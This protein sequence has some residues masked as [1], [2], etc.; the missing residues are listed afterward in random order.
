[1]QSRILRGLVAHATLSLV[2]ENQ[3]SR[4]DFDARA[5]AVAVRLGSDQEDFQPVVRIAAIIAQ[6]LRGLSAIVDQD[7]QVAVVVE[8][9]DGGAAAYAR[10]LKVRPKLVADV[11]KMPRPVLRNIILGSAYLVS[12]W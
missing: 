8:V 10:Q 4:C 1:V 12:A 7:V 11:S 5:H 2:I 6:K 9:A 3:I